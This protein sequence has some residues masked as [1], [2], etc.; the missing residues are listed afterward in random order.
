MRFAMVVMLGLIAVPAPAQHHPAEYPPLTPDGPFPRCGSMELEL[1]GFPDHM[2]AWHW[3]DWTPPVDADGLTYGPGSLC[4]RRQLLEREGLVLEPAMKGWR[5][6]VI[7]HNPGYKPCDM[8]PFME[9]IDLAYRQIRDQI[10]LEV[11]DTLRMVNPDNVNQYRQMTG[12]GT[13]RLYQRDGNDV[14]LQSIGVL[15]ART[16]E[17]H[18][19]HMLVAEW[20]LDKGVGADLPIWLTKGLVDYLGENGVHLVNYMAEFRSDGPVLLAP[21]L[22]EHILTAGVDPDPGRDR[23][24]YRRASYSAFLMVWELVENQGGLAAMREFL[25]AVRDGADPDE[26]ATATWGQDLAGLAR[27]L[28]PVQ[29]GEPIGTAVEARPPHLEP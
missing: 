26:A 2:H 24:M 7:E 17:G 28:D 13:W 9:I 18:A 8:L 11:A 21:P 22:V 12:Q 1:G 23:Q 15:Q 16:L 5:Q 19:A 4:Q 29:L 25:H 10:G 14:I 6:F 3:S 27:M 20:V